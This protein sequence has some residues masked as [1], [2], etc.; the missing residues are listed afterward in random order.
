MS[1]SVLGGAPATGRADGRTST[2][3]PL[4]PAVSPE[5][6]KENPPDRGAVREQ[7]GRGPRTCN[8][9]SHPL[10]WGLQG[11]GAHPSFLALGQEEKQRHRRD[12]WPQRNSQRRCFWVQYLFLNTA[13]PTPAGSC[14]PL[15]SRFQA[16]SAS[17][18]PSSPLT[19]EIFPNLARLSL[20]M[21]SSPNTQTPF[22]PWQLSFLPHCVAGEILVP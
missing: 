3:W 4:S 18:S 10:L 19:T 6:R 13:P 8:Q 7:E 16:N 9:R 5:G 17:S 1:V 21:R 11:Q 12:D 22:F 20:S 15:L 14:L 2:R